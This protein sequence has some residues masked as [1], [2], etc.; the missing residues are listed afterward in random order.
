[1]T[2]HKPRMAPH[3]DAPAGLEQ[4]GQGKPIP[5]EQRIE[6]D[7]AKVRKAVAE[8][9]KNPQNEAEIPAPSLKIMRGKHETSDEPVDPEGQ[10]ANCHPKRSPE[11]RIRNPPSRRKRSDNRM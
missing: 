3:P 2:E 4:D 7:K 10:Q 8:G 1:M 11:Q 6:E 9:I 5:F